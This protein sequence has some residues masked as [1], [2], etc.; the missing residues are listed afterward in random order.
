M[1]ELRDVRDPAT[2]AAAD[3]MKSEAGDAL[4]KSLAFMLITL[5]P[6]GTPRLRATATATL[7]MGETAKWARGIAWGSA[8][9]IATL[10]KGIAL[11][12]K[13]HEDEAA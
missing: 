3:Q 10:E 4:R 6:D 12:I 2:K 5:D 13:R 9:T 11:S 8:K 1:D 7:S